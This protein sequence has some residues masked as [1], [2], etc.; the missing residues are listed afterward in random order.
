[1]LHDVFNVFFPVWERVK[2]RV[3]GRREKKKDKK[4]K[5]EKRGKEIWHNQ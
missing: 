3:E 2:E 1:M 5:R 4:D